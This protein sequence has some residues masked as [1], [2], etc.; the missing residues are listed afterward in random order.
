MHIQLQAHLHACL[1]IHGHH[2][3]SIIS[4]IPHS[5]NIPQISNISDISNIILLD[6]DTYMHMY[7][8]T[9]NDVLV[10]PC[11]LLFTGAT[12]HNTIS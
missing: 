6:V 8:H 4:E 7:A 10:L 9:T 1:P 2:M 11:A 5:Q 3:K 12:A